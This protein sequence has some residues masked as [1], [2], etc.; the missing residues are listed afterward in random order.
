MG[1]GASSHVAVNP[2]PTPH[3][4]NSKTIKEN[5]THDN[6]SVNNTVTSNGSPTS[7]TTTSS[8]FSG[9]KLSVSKR[10]SRRLSMTGGPSGSKVSTANENACRRRLSVATQPSEDARQVLKENNAALSMLSPGD[11]N[12]PIINSSKAAHLPVRWA[13]YS[14]PGNDPMKRVKENQDSVCVKD[15]YG[16]V[17]NQMFFGVFDGH[18]PNGGLAS[19]FVK[20]HLP[21]SWLAGKDLMEEPF[22]AIN[23]GCLT[24]NHELHTSN[25]DV[26]VSGT[27]SITSLLRGNH[28]FVANIGDSRA[29]LGRMSAKGQIKVLDLSSDQK[30]DRP[31]E[32]AR[33]LSCGGRVFE[34]GVPRVW[35]KDVDMPGLAMS[36]SIGDIAA[37]TVGVFAEPELAEVSLGKNDKFIIW[38]S[39]GVWEFISSQ[40]AVDIVAGYLDKSP[41]EAAG[42]LVREST[43]RWNE[44]EDVVDDTTCIVA[45]LDFT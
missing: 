4:N 6:T 5:H 43:K 11:L 31:D 23:R 19:Q 13:E 17:P 33:I 29:V 27:T 40:E 25:I 34:W 14:R 2:E 9:N 30:P 24:T 36:R 10:E 26:Y 18:G 38:A 41:I 12:K 1:C 7:E 22:V 42:A 45:F 44:E 28:L 37:E 8:S 35:M 3:T 32:M 20:E 39:D 21:D 16:G 15:Q